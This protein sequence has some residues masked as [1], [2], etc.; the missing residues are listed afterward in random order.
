MWIWRTGGKKERKKKAE[1]RRGRLRGTN[2]RRKMNKEQKEKKRHIM[3]GL[4]A[5]ATAK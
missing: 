5:E 2:T 4:G 3:R 1:I